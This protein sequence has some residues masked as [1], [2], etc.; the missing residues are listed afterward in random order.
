MMK[1]LNQ[2]ELEALLMLGNA[3][4]YAPSTSSFF[5][6]GH[7]TLDTFSFENRALP[8]LLKNKQ[9]DATTELKVYW[10]RA[11]IEMKQNYDTTERNS[12]VNIISAPIFKKNLVC[13]P[14][15]C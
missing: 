7:M 3:L 8:M 2:E 9:V 12:I 6:G 10:S 5:K 11:L 4:L 14:H 15:E 1:P 13:H